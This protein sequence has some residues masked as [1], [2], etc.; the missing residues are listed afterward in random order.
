MVEKFEKNK[1]K[2]LLLSV[3]AFVG[4]VTIIIIG[5]TLLS[6]N[7]HND[8]KE[9]ELPNVKYIDSVKIEKDAFKETYGN[10]LTILKK[11][12]DQSD[13]MITELKRTLEDGKKKEIDNRQKDNQSTPFLGGKNEILNGMDIKIPPLEEVEKS[14]INAKNDEKNYKETQIETKVE[15]DLLIV[16]SSSNKDSEKDLANEVSK[17]KEKNEKAKKEI[18][19]TIPAGSFV[20]SILLNG[21]DA[22]TSGNAK[23]EPHP[24]VLRILDNA[25]L[26]NRFKAD[27]KECAVVAG[28][29]GELS[30]DRA[31]IRAETLSCVGKDG[32]IYESEG[33]SIG[34]ITGEDG[35]I[36]LSGRVV[37]K[38]GAILARTMAAGFIE[39]MG[40][41]FKESSQTIN[42]TGMGT[43][44][45]LDPNKATQ[46]G[47]YG[48]VGEGAK[49]LSD[50]YLKLND[51]MHPVVEINIGRKCD[52]IFI[53][54]V[55]L[56][57][58]ESNVKG[59]IDAK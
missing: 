43:T 45:T 22:P 42:T 16:D 24:V 35:K 58:I 4:A 1:K 27:I 26:P 9:I 51:Q 57:K 49:K 34:F 7:K 47:I 10:E 40:Q 50:Y 33:N 41:V 53:K 31:I 36:G 44:S 3:T 38:Q 15:N 14:I 25:I 18:K 32:S 37:S 8:K 30:S 12:Q 11:K 55:V 13:K 21:L 28:G 48:G 54:Q 52:I 17:E 19:F 29:Y 23:E 20:K 6:S 56:K 46:I 59:D 5:S 2:Q 39:G